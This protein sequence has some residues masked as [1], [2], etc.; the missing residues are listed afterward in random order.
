MFSFI[1]ATNRLYNVIGYS[2]IALFGTDKLTVFNTMC[3]LYY[4]V[5]VC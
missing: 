2:V 3:I 1:G 4:V 5:K